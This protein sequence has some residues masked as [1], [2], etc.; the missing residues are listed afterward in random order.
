VLRRQSDS[1]CV[2]QIIIAV[3]WPKTSR[4]KKGLRRSLS[5]QLKAPCTTT[6]CYHTPVNLTSLL[7]LFFFIALFLAISSRLDALAITS[8]DPSGDVRGGGQIVSFGRLELTSRQERAQIGT[9]RWSSM[10][11]SLPV[12]RMNHSCL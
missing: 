5:V 8:S 9:M 3:G 2:V 6:S 10:V 4:E 7:A 1:I 12:R 11:S